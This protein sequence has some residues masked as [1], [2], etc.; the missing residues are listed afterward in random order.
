M[1]GLFLENKESSQQNTNQKTGASQNDGEQHG[2]RSRWRLAYLLKSSSP[3]SFG[4]ADSDT[5][6][7]TQALPPDQ[8]LSGHRGK[9]V[10]LSEKTFLKLTFHLCFKGRI[11]IITERNFK[12]TA[13]V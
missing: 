2:S 9:L 12:Q 5:S 6:T 11:T 10:H 8:R 3:T 13:T 7:S 4:A 1:A